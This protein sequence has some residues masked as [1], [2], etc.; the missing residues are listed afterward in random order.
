MQGQMAE[1]DFLFNF[2]I[3]GFS[4]NLGGCEEQ[5]CHVDIICPSNYSRTACLFTYLIIY[6]SENVTL[7]KQ[8][9][10]TFN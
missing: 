9:S 7:R 1:S 4:L 5:F 8:Q 6:K 2:R 10:V 3:T